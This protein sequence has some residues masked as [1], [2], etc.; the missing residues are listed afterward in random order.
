V[1]EK[2]APLGGRRRGH[3]LIFTRTIGDIST[4][5]PGVDGLCGTSID[6]KATR[7]RIDGPTGIFEIKIQNENG[8]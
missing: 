4:G 3:E 5:G 8:K 7:H 1:R 2:T 6:T